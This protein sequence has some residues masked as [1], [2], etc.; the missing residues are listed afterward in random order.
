[1]MKGEGVHESAKEIIVGKWTN[2]ELNDQWRDTVFFHAPKIDGRDEIPTT[3][4]QPRS[5]ETTDNIGKSSE[6]L[7]LYRL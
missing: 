1:M 5:Q 3:Q 7:G 4:P 2:N 6:T